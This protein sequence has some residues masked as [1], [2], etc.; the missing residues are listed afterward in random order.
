MVTSTNHVI[1]EPDL[2]RARPLALRRFSQHL[3][4]KYIGEDQKKSYDFSSGSLADS[5][6]RSQKFAMGGCFWGLGAGAPS[7]WRPMGLGGKAPSPRRLGVWGRS[8][9]RSKFLHFFGKMNL[10]LELF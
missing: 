1:A 3:S 5:Q 6:A 8:L 2:L 7:R 10:I 9:Q 4:A